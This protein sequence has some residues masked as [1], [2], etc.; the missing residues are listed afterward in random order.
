[1]TEDKAFF[2]KVSI[3]N[4]DRASTASGSF[5]SV[6]IMLI[7]VETVPFAAVAVL[8]YSVIA[9]FVTRF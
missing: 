8:L 5:E 4:S 7:S 6:L 2:D 9:G 1:M 3:W